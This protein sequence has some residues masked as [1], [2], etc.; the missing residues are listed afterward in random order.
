M[1]LVHQILNYGSR[2][3]DHHVHPNVA[4]NEVSHRFKI[5]VQLCIVIKTTIHSSLKQFFS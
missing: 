1:T 4:E 5:D 2:V 3:V